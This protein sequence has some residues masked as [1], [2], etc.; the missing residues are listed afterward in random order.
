MRGATPRKS[1]PPEGKEARL[2]GDTAK[3][4]PTSS[5]FLK[6]KLSEKHRRHKKRKWRREKEEGRR[7]RGMGERDKR[8]GRE[9]RKKEE[10]KRKR[11][12]RVRKVE[13][14][15]RDWCEPTQIGAY[16]VIKTLGTP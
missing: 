14:H 12:R 6:R 13:R 4:K 3:D 2:Q 10:K 9:G 5:T 8:G 16:S 7:E 1:S 11:S 15:T